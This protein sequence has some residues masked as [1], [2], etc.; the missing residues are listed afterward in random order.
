MTTGTCQYSYWGMDHWPWCTWLPWW[1]LWYFS[2]PYLQRR[3]CPPWCDDLWYWYGHRWGKSP[4]IWCRFL[5]LLVESWRIV[6]ISGTVHWLYLKTSFHPLLWTSSG[7]DEVHSSGWKLVFKYNQCTVPEITT[8]L[9]VLRCS[10]SLSPKVLADSPMFSSS[11][12]NLLH[13]YC[14]PYPWRQPGGFWWWFLPW[15]GL[16][17]LFCHKCSWSFCLNPLHG[18]PQYGCCCYCGCWCYGCCCY[19]FCLSGAAFPAPTIWYLN[20]LAP[21]VS[22]YT[23]HGTISGKYN[24]GKYNTFPL[25]WKSHVVCHGEMLVLDYIIF[26]FYNL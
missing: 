18:I 17:H 6:V 21:G 19:C 26:C 4:K 5:I 20:L 24:I 2:P 14:C 15:S 22:I 25:T 16:G 8:I 23:S 3:S 1:F 7:P 11:Q 13:L 12:S 9:Q 10:L